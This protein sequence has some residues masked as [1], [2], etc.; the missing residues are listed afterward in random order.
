MSSI[1]DDVE[2]VEVRLPC[3]PNC[4]SQRYIPVK[5]WTDEDGGRTSRRVCEQCSERYVVLTVPN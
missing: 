2:I 4:G 1:W 5:G 3:C